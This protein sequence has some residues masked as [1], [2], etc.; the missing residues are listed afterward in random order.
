LGEVAG[1]RSIGVG[2]HVR[3]SAAGTGGA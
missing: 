1:R 2:G 3:I